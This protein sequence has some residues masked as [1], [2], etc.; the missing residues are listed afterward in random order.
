MLRLAN[1]KIV[2]LASQAYI[3]DLKCCSERSSAEKETSG[4]KFAKGTG[5]T[6]TAL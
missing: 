2:K 6:W 1:N 4:E 3:A 5:L